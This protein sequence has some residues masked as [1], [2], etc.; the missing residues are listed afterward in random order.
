MRCSVRV[1]GLGRKGL[2]CLGRA[3]FPARWLRGQVW[4]CPL[5]NWPSWWRHQSQAKRCESKHGKTYYF[6]FQT[7]KK[8]T[9]YTNR[10]F[11]NTFAIKGFRSQ[12][13]EIYGQFRNMVCGYSCICWVYLD[14]SIFK[15]LASLVHGP[16]VSSCWSEAPLSLWSWSNCD[17]KYTDRLQTWMHQY[18]V[19]RF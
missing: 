13:R 19:V 12:N 15:P 2:C 10:G 7:L 5:N 4:T 17:N 16:A 11:L 6:A 3:K 8:I 1:P 14:D 9:D 18:T